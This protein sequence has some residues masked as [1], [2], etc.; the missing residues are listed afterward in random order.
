[1]KPRSRICETS[2]NFSPNATLMALNVENQYAALKQHS[3]ESLLLYKRRIEF[4]L[5]MYDA[6][7][8]VRPPHAT[9][10]NNMMKTVNQAKYRHSIESLMTAVRENVKP[11]PATTQEL[12]VYLVDV[13]PI[14]VRIKDRT[15]P[16]TPRFSLLTS[17]SMQRLTALRVF[18]HVT[19]TFARN[20]Y[21]R[22]TEGIGSLNALI[23]TNSID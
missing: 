17:P 1:M 14:A 15:T 3:N 10:V 21:H 13:Y 18:H 4:T 6:I 9:V 12:Y 2:T 7:R 19:V 11:F 23:S 16:A 8:L 22:R 20:T 5:R